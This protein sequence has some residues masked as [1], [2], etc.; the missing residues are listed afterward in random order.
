MTK[1]DNNI[2]MR[3]SD[4]LANEEPLMWAIKHNVLNKIFEENDI[5]IF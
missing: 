2:T 1:L 3:I 5:D 4:R